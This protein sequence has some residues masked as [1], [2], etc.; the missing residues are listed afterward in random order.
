MRFHAYEIVSPGSFDLGVEQ[1]AE[2]LTRRMA[3]DLQILADDRQPVLQVRVGL[4]E[5]DDKADALDEIRHGRWLPA[6]AQRA[7]LK[8][9]GW[10]S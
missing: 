7:A 5:A 4:V 10:G 9:A 8:R 2:D 6:A 3:G 1:S